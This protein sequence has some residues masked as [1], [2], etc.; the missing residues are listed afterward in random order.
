MVR[1]LRSLDGA[2]EFGERQKDKRRQYNLVLGLSIG[3]RPFLNDLRDGYY[4]I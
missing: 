2:R 1:D 4:R 3:F